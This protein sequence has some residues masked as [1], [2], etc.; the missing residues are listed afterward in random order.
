MDY[1][2]YLIPLGNISPQLTA[3]L[4]AM[5]HEQSELWNATDTSFRPRAGFKTYRELKLRPPAIMELLRC[6]GMWLPQ[7][8]F[9]GYE[10]NRLDCGAVLEEHTDIAAKPE[11]KQR[12]HEITKFHK[13]NVALQGSAEYWFRR[14]LRLAPEQAKPIQVGDM[15]LFNNYVY[16]EVR[17]TS[18]EP[19]INLTLFYTDPEWKTKFSIYNQLGLDTNGY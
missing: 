9:R 14:D 12:A 6:A 1:S 18:S 7:D 8:T 4:L 5:V 10:A 15:T 17:C 3:D 13:L 19:R 16:H 2:E 11:Y